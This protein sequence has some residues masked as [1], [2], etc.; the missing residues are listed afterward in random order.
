MSEVELQVWDLTARALREGCC[1]LSI[2][3][4]YPVPHLRDL[5]PGGAVRVCGA[6]VKRVSLSLFQ[7]PHGLTRTSVV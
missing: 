3:Q 4:R 6:A 7:C 1:V 5:T 2:F